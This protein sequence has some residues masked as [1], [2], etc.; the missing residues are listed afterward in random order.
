MARSLSRLC[1]NAAF[2][3]GGI[4]PRFPVNRSAS[5]TGVNERLS[6]NNAGHAPNQAVSGLSA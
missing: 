6:C 4:V 1:A 3:D 2:S 5:G